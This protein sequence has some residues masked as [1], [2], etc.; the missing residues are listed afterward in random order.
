M[1]YNLIVAV[2]RNNGIGNK[3]QIPWH[4]PQD[5]QYFSKLTRG[6]GL[7]AVIMGNTTWKNLPIP[8]GKPKGLPR[9]DNFVLARMDS[10]DM[11]LNHDHLMKTFKTIDEL[12]TYISRHDIYEDIWVIGG[13]TIY[14]QFLERGNVQK[15]YVTY[16]D[17]D[18]DCD[19]FFPV[20]DS[21]EWK[22]IERTESYDTGYQCSVI[23]SVFH[24]L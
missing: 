21:T 18:F 22:E 10:F 14:K 17:A 2:C 11:V 24:K 13:E 19:T 16:I 5:L 23:Y 4:L 1:R 9:R 15:C 6:D 20:L 12:E 3:G 8:T 7:N